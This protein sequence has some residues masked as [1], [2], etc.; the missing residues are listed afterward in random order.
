MQFLYSCAAVD[1]IS[2][3]L[4]HRMIPLRFWVVTYHLR[5]R[6]RSTEMALLDRSNVTSY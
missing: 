6:L 4:G 1:K 2:A 5:H 3:V